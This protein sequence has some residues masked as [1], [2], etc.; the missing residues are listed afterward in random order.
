MA[1]CNDGKGNQANHHEKYG[2]HLYLDHMRLTQKTCIVGIP[3][4]RGIQSRSMLRLYG[5]SVGVPWGIQGA[6]P[7]H[8]TYE[9]CLVRTIVEVRGDHFQFSIFNS[10]TISIVLTDT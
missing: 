3:C 7:C 9:A 1:I 2:I 5:I 4:R 6:R 10:P 8:R